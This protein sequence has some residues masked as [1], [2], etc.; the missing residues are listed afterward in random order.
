MHDGFSYIEIDDYPLSS[1]SITKWSNHN[2]TVQNNRF[3]DVKTNMIA[4]KLL[5]GMSGQSFLDNCKV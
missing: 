5:D 3:P 2:H 4:W 1:F